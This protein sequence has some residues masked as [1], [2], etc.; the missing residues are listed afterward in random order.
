MA[1]YKIKAR[2]ARGQ[3]GMVY[4]YQSIQRTGVKDPELK[5]LKIKIPDKFW[6]ADK[7]RISKEL[8]DKYLNQFEQFKSVDVL[9]KYITEKKE[10][11]IKAN[12]SFEFINNE[13]KTVNDWCQKV[14]DRTINQGTKAR[15]KNIRN[16]L[17]KYQL[18]YSVHHQKKRTPTKIMY[19]KDITVDWINYFTIWLRTKN[20]LPNGKIGNAVN[21]A[22]YK[23]KGIKTM[24][25]K[26]HKERWYVFN[27]NPFTLISLK[28]EETQIEILTLE[29][30]IRMK[31]TNYVEVKRTRIKTKEGANRWGVPIEEGVEARNKKNNR[32]KAKHT[33]GDIS[34]YFQFQLFAQGIRVS[35]LLTLR[36]NDFTF[37]NELRINKRMVKTKKFINV[38]VNDMM[39]DIIS[40]Y[41]TKHEMFAG[42]AIELEKYNNTLRNIRNILKDPF[43]KKDAKEIAAIDGEIYKQGKFKL[44]ES[45]ILKLASHKTLKN[46][47]VFG[48]MDNKFFDGSLKEKDEDGKLKFPAVDDNNDFGIMTETQYVKFQSAKTYYNNLLKLVA[49]QAG[50]D[51]N[52]KSHISR[53]SYCSLLLEMGE[54]INLYDLMQSLGHAHLSTT[55]GYIK[56]F[57]SKNVDRLNMVISKKVD[58]G[59][60]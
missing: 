8:P 32:Y 51:K 31:E 28:W 4:L 14:I 20:E 2:T 19:F 55:E 60:F 45:M 38:L 30:L 49:V 5:G 1:T 44:V 7:E 48:L 11:L 24:I 17:E 33:L 15:Y 52:L 41:I 12:G 22:N 21:S 3:K 56:K 18:Y 25:N 47:F 42:E 27:P 50:I 36:W 39:I 35:D 16:L 29:E 10:D 26:A 13:E 40:C 23:T 37:D 43:I 46:E 53:H 9:N 59:L 54:N 58:N 34:R 57:V 6:I